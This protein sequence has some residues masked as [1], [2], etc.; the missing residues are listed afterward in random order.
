[1]S[2]WKGPNQSLCDTVLLPVSVKEAQPIT[3]WHGFTSCLCERDPTKHCVTVL[4]PVTVKGTQPI[5]VWQFYFQPPRK[6][7]N[8]SVWHCFTSCFCERDPTKHCVT[9]LLP[10]SAEETQTIS[11]WQFYFLPLW[12]RPNQSLC[13]TI[14]CPSERDPVN[15][16]VTLFYLQSP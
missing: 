2:F 16:S 15:L 8:Q 11:V 13:N 6:R 1:M 10:A 3:V 14:S 12:K 4:L 9:V 5:T 7:P